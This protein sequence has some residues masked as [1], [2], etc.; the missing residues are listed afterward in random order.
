MVLLYILV[1]ILVAGV[2]FVVASTV[3][4][5]GEQLPPLPRATT[6]S[7]LPASGVSRADI[8]AVNFTQTLRGF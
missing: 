3:F 7:V 8:D 5:R 2:L 1:L 6:A 4:G